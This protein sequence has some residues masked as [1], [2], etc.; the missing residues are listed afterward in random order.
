[1]KTISYLLV[2]LLSMSFCL[3]AEAVL[4]PDDFFLSP[5]ASCSDRLSPKKSTKEDRF[6]IIESQK[7]AA[8]FVLFLSYDHPLFERWIERSKSAED[9]E[10]ILHLIW[11]YT[12]PIYVEPN[13]TLKRGIKFGHAMPFIPAIRSYKSFNQA[14]KA[15]AE[16]RFQFPVDQLKLPVPQHV[17][18]TFDAQILSENF[19]HELHEFF[20]IASDWS[21]WRELSFEY[22]QKFVNQFMHSLKNSFSST[23]SN[24]LL[25]ESTAEID[26]RTGKK[27]EFLT[28]LQRDSRHTDY[29]RYTLTLKS[30][31]PLDVFLPDEMEKFIRLV[32]SVTTPSTHTHKIVQT[33]LI[34][35]F[36][37]L[38]QRRMEATKAQDMVAS[39]RTSNIRLA[40]KRVFEASNQIPNETDSYLN[41]VPLNE[42]KSTLRALGTLQA[43][44]RADMSLLTES[45]ELLHPPSEMKATADELA[46]LVEAKPYD[47]SKQLLLQSPE[48]IVNASESKRLQFDALLQP[49]IEDLKSAADVQKYGQILFTYL[50]QL[51]VALGALN[52]ERDQS[53]SLFLASQLDSMTADSLLEVTG[54]FLT[55]YKVAQ[56]NTLAQ[57]LHI[58]DALQKFIVSVEDH[59][60]LLKEYQQQNSASE[61]MPLKLSVIEKIED[62]Q[63]ILILAKSQMQTSIQLKHQN[64][65]RLSK[66]VRDLLLQI[67]TLNTQKSLKPLSAEDLRGFTESLRS[68]KNA[69]EI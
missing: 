39:A 45:P 36:P 32:L 27:Y 51:S 48:K 42:L 3:K 28:S 50:N 21:K 62:L 9:V 55:H 38:M 53:L 19:N 34:D 20:T 40:K 43:R 7:R 15:Y 60:S 2:L 24:P 6:A 41:K 22:R 63:S 26:P 17:A 13:L 16:G 54:Q 64:Q 5:P 29:L 44:I 68:L 1:M 30:G 59:L 4:P 33:Y 58:E 47:L 52:T 18:D 11:G 66:I 31:R 35:H 69:L 46:L 25:L 56:S 61:N 23:Y 49:R 67:A 57:L 14:Y 8:E 10:A 12:A 37:L 65:S